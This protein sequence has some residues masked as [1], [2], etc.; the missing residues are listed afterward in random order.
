MANKTLG[1]RQ[2][3]VFRLLPAPRKPVT[4]PARPQKGR[5]PGRR[6]AAA[7][8]TDDDA[9]CVPENGKDAPDDGE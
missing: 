1:T 5:R 7:K 9:Q 4:V 3:Q 2:K 8:R 6:G